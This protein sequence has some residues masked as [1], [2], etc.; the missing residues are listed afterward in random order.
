MLVV[1]FTTIYGSIFCVVCGFVFE[2]RVVGCEF[3]FWC[4]L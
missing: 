3:Y 4:C 2:L 1:G